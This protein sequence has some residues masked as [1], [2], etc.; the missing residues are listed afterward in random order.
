MRNE[1]NVGTGCRM[2]QIQEYDKSPSMVK[3]AGQGLLAYLTTPERER[4][5][6]IANFEVNY[7]HS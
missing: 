2:R 6:E 5:R 4:E 1:W 7:W 3:T